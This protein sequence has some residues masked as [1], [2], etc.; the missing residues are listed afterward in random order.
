[1][2]NKHLFLSYPVSIFLV[3]FVLLGADANLMAISKKDMTNREFAV[4]FFNKQAKLKPEDSSIDSSNLSPQFD[5]K[6]E[7]WGF[8][9]KQGKWV[10]KPVFEEVKPFTEDNCA[11]V[12]FDNYYG[13]INRTFG[14]L[15]PPIFDSIF[16]S[17]ING[18]YIASCHDLLW[19]EYSTKGYE[20][21][22]EEILANNLQTESFQIYLANTGDLLC[23]DKFINANDFDMFC[24]ALVQTKEGFGLLDRNGKFLVAPQY[25]I[26]SSFGPSGLY[27]IKKSGKYGIVSK[28]G[29]IILPPDY[30]QMDSWNEDDL[31]WIKDHSN[32]WGLINKDGEIIISPKFDYREN[33][34]RN[35]YSVVVSDGKYGIINGEGTILRACDDDY[36]VNIDGQYW[37]IKSPGNIGL[38]MI[39]GD[40]I[41]YV[42]MPSIITDSIEPFDI[43]SDYR[44]SYAETF[45]SRIWLKGLT[46]CTFYSA[47]QDSIESSLYL[48]NR[49]RD[50][51]VRI[52]WADSVRFS[53]RPISANIWTNLPISKSVGVL[54]CNSGRDQEL[55]SNEYVAG[56]YDIDQDGNEELLLAMRD[57]TRSF[58]FKPNGACLNI[59]KL[60]AMGY[61]N[62]IGSESIGKGFISSALLIDDHVRSI[63]G[64][65][66]YRQ[67]IPQKSNF[68]LTG[69]VEKTDNLAF[70]KYGN[71]CAIEDFII[72]TDED[73]YYSAICKSN[74]SKRN[75]SLLCFDQDRISISYDI[76]KSQN[77]DTPDTYFC[78]WYFNTDGLLES[79]T[80][81]GPNKSVSKYYLYNKSGAQICS[82]KKSSS[83]EDCIII[84]SYD[85]PLD[86]NGN[87]TSRNGLQI[88]GSGVK[89][90]IK[91]TRKIMYYPEPTWEK[92]Y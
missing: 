18:V 80:L 9:S 40:E 30:I 72:Q 12:K 61:W 67:G 83:G 11:I 90:N 51:I 36:I 75:I 20:K 56:T 32:K 47:K 27:Q 89:T 16:C 17:S 28:E 66:N 21:H 8:V 70:D 23:S 79:Y 5:S 6:S 81:E 26:I 64:T 63:S 65:P 14:F 1:M 44:S 50:F 33:L 55:I 53:V 85:E 77:Y 68:G 91:E 15:F 37:T 7:R 54:D 92:L 24:I 69:K 57:N 41:S 73:S 87:W 71:L 35:S 34:T 3:L 74:Q 52:D 38:Y 76:G 13:I 60:D 42:Q 59:Y 49:N 10:I 39:D 88:T 46:N 22:R 86:N 31:I 62:Q 2:L 82:I 29:S 84:Y 25:E 78:T 43:V 4:S 45:N 19:D 48:H 58:D